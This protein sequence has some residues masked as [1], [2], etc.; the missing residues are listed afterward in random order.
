MKIE[1]HGAGQ[2][3]E[4][5]TSWEWARKCLLIGF[6]IVCV[7]SL[8]GCVSQKPQADADAQEKNR[9][10]G[11][12]SP[13][14]WKDESILRGD[15]SIAQLSALAND[16]A[17]TE[18]ERA[19]AVFELFA[20]HVR[21]GC[22]AAE[23]RDVFSN[24]N[25]LRDCRLHGVYFLGGWVPVDMR[26][27]DIDT[28]FSLHLFPAASD[29]GALWVIY[30]RLTGKM[31]EGGA[32]AF[33]AGEAKAGNPTKLVEFALCFP[34]ST[35]P[36]GLPGHIERFSSRGIHVYSEWPDSSSIPLTTLRAIVLAEGRFQRDLAD[37]KH[38]LPGALKSAAVVVRA[39]VLNAD[40]AVEASPNQEEVSTG[41]GWR[42]ALVE[43]TSVLQGSQQTGL[44][45]VANGGF[46]AD[47]LHWR[48]PIEAT[49]GQR[50]ILVLERDDRL[51]RWCQTN[52][53]AIVRGLEVK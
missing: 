49:N 48:Y 19:G 4:V 7:A 33:L 36:G 20:H 37:I 3:A 38:E 14:F 50:C 1:R 39:K 21:P 12:E 45:W 8:G 2:A 13:S 34:H 31:R 52:V 16:S 51:S 18:A 41:Q 30:F 17:N 6:A 22:S 10:P 26:S 43:S 32:R 40:S 5:T 9:L 42:A 15:R 44:L 53:F 47:G 24:T 27:S 23:F 35:S 29:K 46:R 28:V 11:E 25:W